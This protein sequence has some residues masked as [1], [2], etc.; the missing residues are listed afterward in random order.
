MKN[1]RSRAKGGKIGKNWGRKNNLRNMQ[2]ST[3]N[4]HLHSLQ[5]G[6]DMIIYNCEREIETAAT[7]ENIRLGRLKDM[8]RNLKF[9]VEIE[10][11]GVSRQ[12]VSDALNR[13]GV[14]A[15]AEGYNH[16]TRGY[17]KVVTDASVN[18]SGTG[19]SNG[20]G[21]EIVSPI[22]YGEEGL[23]ELALVC[24]VLEE[25]GAKVDK[26]CGVHVHH[27]AGNMNIEHIKNVY[28]LYYKFH[29]AVEYMMPPSRRAG[30]NRYCK[31]IDRAYI[32]RV[33]RASSIENLRSIICP[34]PGYDRYY[35]VN[36]ASHSKYGTIEFRQHSGSVDGLK[37][38][39]WVKITHKLMEKAFSNKKVELAPDAEWR[40]CDANW[41]FRQCVGKELEGYVVNR[42]AYWRN[43][44][45]N[46]ANRAAGM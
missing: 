41:W 40:V 2:K 31:A 20:S 18:A 11:F 13:A 34:N 12:V 30:A 29:G 39:N 32:E 19:N 33:E 17:W 5:G 46:E 6:Y 36:F 23:R 4:L 27:D 10:F 24:K 8:K 45:K 22:L 15:Y 25:C 1:H 28:K 21:N 14:H 9:G 44:E 35:S 16:E 43:K 7:A 3:K 38:V 42:M 26:S 37:L